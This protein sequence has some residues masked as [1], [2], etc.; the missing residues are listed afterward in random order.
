MDL[1]EVIAEEGAK[2]RERQ[3][4]SRVFVLAALAVALVVALIALVRV[5]LR[6]SDDASSTAKRAAGAATTV[7]AARRA[8]TQS[9]TAKTEN[10]Q[11]TPSSN[12]SVSVPTNS[13]PKS[14]DEQGTEAKKSSH[15]AAPLRRTAPASTAA[16]QR[17]IAR[18]LP[19]SR[20]AGP[21]PKRDSETDTQA[22]IKTL[23]F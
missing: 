11:P 4:R 21:A 20:E 13:P 17:A 19:R 5:A 23:R 8:E 6:S 9:P 7:G 12:A 2:H 15:G 3:Q 14:K 18:D 10:A 22:V 16:K 1:G